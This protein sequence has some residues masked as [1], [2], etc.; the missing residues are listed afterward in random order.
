M[1]ATVTWD[2]TN[3]AGGDGVIDTADVAGNWT[4]V[5]ITAGG[6]GPSAIAADA[7]YEGT[8]NVTCRS[9]NRRVYMYTDIGVG[10]EL[11][12]TVSGNAEGELIY[13]WVNFLASPLLAL[14]SAGGLGIFLESSTP[15][16]SQYHLWYFYG[17]D[18]YTGGWKRLVL[19]PTK[20][21]SASSGTAIDLSAVRYVGAFAHN[22]QG[23]AKY[24]NFVVD[25]CAV[26]RGLIVTGTS[27]T[28]ALIADLIADENTNKRG[29]VVPLNASETSVELNGLLTLGDN[30]GTVATALTDINSKMFT[31]EPLYYQGAVQASV[32]VDYAGL[33]I[34]GNATG[35]TDVTFGKAVGT[36]TGRNGI[37]II[38][39]PTYDFFIDR[40]DAA[41]ESADFYGSSFGN[42]TGVINLDGSHTF[43]GD[44]MVGCGAVSVSSDINNLT[45]VG[46]DAITLEGDANLLNSLIINNTATSAVI[47]DDLTKISACSFTSD[48]TGHAVNL[49]TI[50]ATDTMTWDNTDSGYAGTDGSTG[51]ETIL[52]SIDAGQVLTINVGSGYSTPTVYNTG[53][54][55]FSVVSGQVTLGITVKDIDDASLLEN[56]RVYVTAAAG[57]SLSV[58][59]VIINKALTNA[60]G[61]TS[62]TR[63]YPTNQ[64]ITGK[65]RF[66]TSPNFYKTSPVAGT[67][68][69]ASGLDLT[70]QMI[71][72]V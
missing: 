47:V 15:S 36:T 9:D 72:D 10:N 23:A 62:D 19:D 33:R 28:D 57:G 42:L 30:V 5:K 17:R 32:P 71:K 25:Q 38:G 55:T 54:G 46:S 63:S 48:G 68:N 29:I 13:I 41:V 12:F 8:N 56:A 6:G 34:V 69:N 37:S 31:A 65:V 51:N 26:G 20:T 60:S 66:S 24:D 58:G 35:N 27:T 22:D 49:G 45:S 53:T 70:I 7:A 4:A 11:D 39:N 64:P 18:N 61:Y 3:G 67:I 21:V 52:V 2:G 14:N 43:N 1:A 59:T 44:T 50:A 16:A 40:D